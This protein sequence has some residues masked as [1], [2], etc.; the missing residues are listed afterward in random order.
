MEVVTEKQ[1]KRTV[2]QHREA[3][4]WTQG[5]LAK[6]AGVSRPTVIKVENNKSYRR[7]GAAEE[8]QRKVFNALDRGEQERRDRAAQFGVDAYNATARA[9]QYLEELMDREAIT[10]G[11]ALL[12]IANVIDEFRA[13]IEDSDPQAVEDAARYKSSIIRSRMR[14]QAERN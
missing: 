14:T 8:S 9:V 11:G 12:C 2:K 3:L 5:R 13:T 1:E 4:G 10:P 6:E 7:W